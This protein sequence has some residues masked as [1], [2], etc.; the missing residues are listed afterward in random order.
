MSLGSMSLDSRSLGSGVACAVAAAAVAA[1]KCADAIGAGG[2]VVRG[3]PAAGA[4][5]ATACWEPGFV[6]GQL[7]S[8]AV[9]L[10]NLL[11]P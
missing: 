10:A 7:G 8:V 3:D 9:Q 2:A 5:D 1:A 11:P 4:V 6:A